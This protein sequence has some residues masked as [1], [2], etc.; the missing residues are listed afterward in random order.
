MH[1]N[2]GPQFR[3][4]LQRHD[5]PLMMVGPWAIDGHLLAFFNG[6]IYQAE[7]NCGT[8]NKISAEDSL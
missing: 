5:L 7:L 1:K 2:V 8:T 4:E 6:H 3:D